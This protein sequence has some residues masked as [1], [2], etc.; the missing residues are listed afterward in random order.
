MFITED[1]PTENPVEESYWVEAAERADSLGVN[2]INTSLG[3]TTFD[4]SGM[5]HGITKDLTLEV[6]EWGG[7]REDNWGNHRIAFEAKA[8]LD[9]R[10]FGLKWN[11]PLNKAKG[12]TVG[13]EVKLE[14]QIQ[15]MRVKPSKTKKVSKK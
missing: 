11:K 6:E 5:L 13:N 8:K 10:D 4:N 12:L 9:R 15:G 2:I 1:A 3:Y 7:L 14:L